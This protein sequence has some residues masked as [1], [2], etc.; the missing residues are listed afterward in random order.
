VDGVALIAQGLDVQHEGLE[1]GEE[2]PPPRLTVL[3]EHPSRQ[4]SDAPVRSKQDWR[5]VVQRAEHCGLY[6]QP[7]PCAHQ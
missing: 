3:Q 5:A 7:I 4:N 2:W 1:Q 6:E